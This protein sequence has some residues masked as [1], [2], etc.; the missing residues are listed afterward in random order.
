MTNI[1]RGGSVSVPKKW[2][3]D[4]KWS[5]S[6]VLCTS[7]AGTQSKLMADFILEQFTSREKEI[8]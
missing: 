6:T 5:A 4:V 1:Y 7:N 3:K 8:I 2:H